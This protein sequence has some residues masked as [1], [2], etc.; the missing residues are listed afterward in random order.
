MIKSVGLSGESEKQKSSKS[1]NMQPLL[2][3]CK[4]VVV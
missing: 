1:E 4:G 2:G 3:V